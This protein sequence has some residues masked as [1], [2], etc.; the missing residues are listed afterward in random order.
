MPSYAVVLLLAGQ[1]SRFKDRDK[2]VYADLDGRAVWLRGLE[3]FAVREDVAQILIVIA[4]EDQ[5][6]FDRR[7]RANLAFLTNAMLLYGGKE[8][9]DSVQNALARCSPDIDYVAVHDGARPCLTAEMVNRVFTKAVETGAAMLACRVSDTL[10]RGDP[11][12]TVVETLS[13][14]D[15]WLAQTPQVFRRQLLL[16]A[17]ANRRNS[18]VPITDDAQLV[19]AFGAKVHLVESD[20][21]NLKLTTKAD[22]ALAAAILKSRPKP[23]GAGSAHPFGD[24]GMW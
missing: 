3:V 18:R 5:E 13:R 8:R 20:A 19:E 1:S 21:S 12:N 14:K 6:L 15:L 22:L 9:V 4:E 11:Q 17:Y 16:D 23:K 10:K 24:E 7:Y 2:K